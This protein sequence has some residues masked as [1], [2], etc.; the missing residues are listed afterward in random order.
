MNFF[1]EI[2]K[3]LG[4]L[5]G[6]TLYAEKGYLC[7]LRIEGSLKVQI[8]HEVPEERILIASF[9][10]ELPPGKFREDLLKEALKANHSLEQLGIFAYSPKNNSLTYFLYVS[11]KIDFEDFARQFSQW[12]EIAKQWKSAIETGNIHQLAKSPSS[13][14]GR[15]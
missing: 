11:D 13:F 4:Q 6:T 3:K 2:I 9:L 8:E 14:F 1:E 7:K 15:L 12:L 10:S 5:L